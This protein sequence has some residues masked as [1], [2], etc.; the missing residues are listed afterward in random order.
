MI[1]PGL[2]SVL[3][4]TLHSTYH[5]KEISPNSSLDIY[6]N[7]SL[8]IYSNTSLDIYP[9]TSLD[10]YS[11]SDTSD[12]SWEE[13]NKRRTKEAE[14]EAKILFYIDRIYR[15]NHMFYQKLSYLN[16]TL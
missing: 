10:I 8:D 9:N 1:N 6:S 3:T 16:K 4:N 14:Q 11:N 5:Q 12:E 15:C 7:T 2:N 13:Y